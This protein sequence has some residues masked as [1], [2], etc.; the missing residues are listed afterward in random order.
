MTD[1]TFSEVLEK[2]RRAPLWDWLRKY[3]HVERLGSEEVDGLL[4]GE[5]YVQ[6]KIDGAN[7]TVA[8]DEARG[9]VI[10]SRN[11]VISFG[12]VPDNGMRG[13]VEYVLAHPEYGELAKQGYVLRGEWLVTHSIVYDKKSLNKLYIFDV[14]KPDG[15]YLTPDEYEPLL[16]QYNIPFVPV[17]ARFINSTAEEI[18]KLVD[19]PDEW[20]A[21]QKEGVVVKRI[22]FINCFGRT[23]WGKIVAADFKKKN[24]ITY[25]KVDSM[26]LRFATY[27]ITE[28]G[29]LKI[30]HK[31]EDTKGKRADVRDMAQVIGRSW[32]E[33][34]SE[35]LW[36]FVK[37]EHV[38]EFNF[39][40]ARRLVEA[41]TR[42][43]AL[44]YFNGVNDDTI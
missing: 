26:E 41:R 33:A 14:E 38:A 21:T 6:T 5:V 29:I 11:T 27:S 12:G 20:G 22:G 25:H 31:I 42:M 3:Q 15:T 35:F 32:N 19:G 16:K 8:W 34:F 7:A 13:L 30:I 1:Q 23:V 4:E 17:L 10:A 43:I 28:D 36:D 44:E 40:E 39:K 2:N 9:V 24:K 37:Q 18:A